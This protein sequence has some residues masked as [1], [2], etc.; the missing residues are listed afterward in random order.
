MWEDGCGIDAGSKGNVD[1]EEGGSERGKLEGPQ[2][3]ATEDEV[4]R[5]DGQDAEPHETGCKAKHGYT[6]LL[7]SKRQEDGYTVGQNSRC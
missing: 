1:G 7:D 6:S 2:L 3:D 5:S 4:V